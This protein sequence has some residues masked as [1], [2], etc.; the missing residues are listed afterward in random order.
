MK[1]CLKINQTGLLRYT[2]VQINLITGFI[3]MVAMLL[4]L[5]QSQTPGK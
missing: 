4:D 5:Y 3:E 2:E 1:I